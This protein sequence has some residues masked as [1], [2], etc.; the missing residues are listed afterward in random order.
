MS[1]S[2]ARASAA[3]IYF[4]TNR[5]IHGLWNS[6]IPSRFLDEL[7]EAHVEVT[8][9]KGGFGNFGGGQAAYGASRFDSFAPAGSSYRHARL[10][11]RAEAQARRR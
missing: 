8:E 1:G 7:P 6:T 10:A 9:S 5:R 3:K 4:A 11:A 2:R